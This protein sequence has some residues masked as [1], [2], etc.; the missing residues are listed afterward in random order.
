MMLASVRSVTRTTN[1]S[2]IRDS[3]RAS[4]IVAEIRVA[5]MP[6][7]YYISCELVNAVNVEK[8]KLFVHGRAMLILYSVRLP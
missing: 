2:A 6:Y 4:D 8:N 7:R 3:R 5:G 1:Q